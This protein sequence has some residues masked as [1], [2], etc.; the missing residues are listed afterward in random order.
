[1]LVGFLSDKV[2]LNGSYT[3]CN[4]LKIYLLWKHIEDNLSKN[5]FR[6]LSLYVCACVFTCLFLCIQSPALW[7]DEGL[8]N[9]QGSVYLPDSG[10]LSVAAKEDNSQ[11][12]AVIKM[13]WLDKNPP[14]GYECDT[15][16]HKQRLLYV[17]YVD[18][19]HTLDKTSILNI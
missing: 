7:Q 10:R 18:I 13:G 8:S 11:L 1:M 17:L 2:Q 14:Q 9:L 3:I 16:T 15:C 4:S 5:N 12:I 6:F 19:F